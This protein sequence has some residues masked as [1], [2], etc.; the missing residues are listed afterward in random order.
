M[1]MTLSQEYLDQIKPQLEKYSEA[2]LT[3]D[4]IVRRLE[5]AGFPQDAIEQLVKLPK[6]ASIPA[7]QEKP[8]L[9]ELCD[10][11]AI[12]LDSA[13]PKLWDR[14]I[15]PNETLVDLGNWHKRLREALNDS[16]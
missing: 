3:Y 6:A 5:T 11:L 13:I 15:N 4:E 12:F 14:G 1:P 2:G 8:D 9:L 16:H 7:I 10:S